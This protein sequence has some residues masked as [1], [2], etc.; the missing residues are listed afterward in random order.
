MADLIEL[1]ERVE[2]ARSAQWN[3]VYSTIRSYRMTNMR[4]DIGGGYP[5]VDLMSNDG[6]SIATGE[7]EMEM[8]A[9]EIIIVLRALSAKEPS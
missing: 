2:G 5:L 1:A 3:A 8:L 6:C 9:D 7:E 4:D